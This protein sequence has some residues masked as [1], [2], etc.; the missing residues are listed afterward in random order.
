MPFSAASSGLISTNELRLQLGQPRQPAAHR[1]GQVVLG[2][3][4]GGQDVGELRIADRGER[5]AVDVPVLQHRAESAARVER[6][7]D[8]RLDRLVVRRQRAVD[9]TGR[10]EEPAL[11]VAFMMNGSVPDSASRP[12]RARLRLGVGRLGRRRSRARR[13]RSTSFCC[14]VPPDP[15]LPLAPRVCRPVGRGA[16]V[17]DA[18][19]GRPGEA[20]AQVGCAGAS[21]RIGRA[22]RPRGS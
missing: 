3:P 6:V 1:P 11:A 12:M 17:H 10:G 15:L 16:V 2:Q 9:E 20:P 22:A 8:R 18:P 4:I 13:S 19:V 5:I 21:R 14:R 7:L